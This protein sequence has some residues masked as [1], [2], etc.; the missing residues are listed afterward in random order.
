MVSNLLNNQT[1]KRMNGMNE[2]GE[3]GKYLFFSMLSWWPSS[4]DR[5]AANGRP[6][7]K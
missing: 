6:F 5:K 1:G 3:I 7:S 4:A 2:G